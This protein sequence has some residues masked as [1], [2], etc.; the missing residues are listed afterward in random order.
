MKKYIALLLAL[1]MLLLAACGTAQPPVDEQTP[2]T[3][4]IEPSGT[5][6]V[7]TDPVNP[8]DGTEDTTEPSTD[9]PTAEPTEEPTDEPTA[10]PSEAPTTEPTTEGGSS[11]TDGTEVTTPPTTPT[12]DTEPSEEPTNP[13]VETSVKLDKTEVVLDIGGTVTLTATTTGSGTLSWSSNN[14]SVATVSN[15]KVTAKAA[16][17]AKIT[18]SYGGKTATCTIKVNEVKLSVSPTSKTLDIG[19]TVT[20][21]ATYSGATGKPTWTSSNTSVATVDSNGKVTAKAAGDAVIT[22]TYGGKNAQCVIKVN[23]PAAEVTLKLNKSG[24]ALEVG[25]SYTLTATTTSSGTLTWSSSDT[26]VATVDS[27][28]KVTAKAAG[29]SIITASYGGKK[30][31]CI[32]EVTAPAE[33]EPELGPAISISK[34]GNNGSWSSG[35]VGNSLSFNVA[36]KTASGD[37]RDVVASSSNTGVATVSCSMSSGIAY[38]KVSFKSAGS[39][40]ITLKSDDGEQSISFDISVSNY[41]TMSVSSPES[42]AAAAT[43]VLTQNGLSQGTPGNYTVLTLSADEL[44]WSSARAN[45]EWLAHRG[46]SAGCSC[47][48]VT[49]EGQNEDGQYIFYL[50]IG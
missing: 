7:Q 1:A 40:T 26:S 19:G 41:S 8:T 30:A 34:F 22:A 21:T 45:G 46:W 6:V 35:K 49:Y 44:T 24:I 23:A 31:Q 20:L 11:G 36:A 48:S 4:V 27:N 15:G 2:S 3:E 47:G 17:T 43:S 5:E 25:E 16:G 18:V 50:R 29:V 28:G 9:E 14:T 12:E 10:E 38:V 33:T 42:Y 37:N 39:T 13:P 32:V